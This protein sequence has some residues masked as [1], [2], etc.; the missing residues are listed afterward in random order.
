MSQHRHTRSLLCHGDLGLVGVVFKQ[1]VGQPRDWVRRLGLGEGSEALGQGGR[2]VRGEVLPGR[3][4][5]NN[6]LNHACSDV[7]RRW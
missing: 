7:R 4:A 5:V 3:V 6:G 1:P 2:D